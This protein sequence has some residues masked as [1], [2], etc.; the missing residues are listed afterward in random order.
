MPALACHSVCFRPASHGPTDSPPDGPIHVRAW[1]Y[2]QVF[3]AILLA[4]TCM[5]RATE[6]MEMPSKAQ[7]AE[8]PSI[9]LMDTSED[10]A[11][12]RSQ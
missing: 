2:T 8:P 11:I 3:A 7:P 10:H 4:S 5:A 6:H 9:I 12:T 1:A